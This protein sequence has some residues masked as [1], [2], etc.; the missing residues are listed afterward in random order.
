MEARKDTEERTLLSRVPGPGQQA[1][2]VLQLP[3]RQP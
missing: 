2:A 1:K 3:H